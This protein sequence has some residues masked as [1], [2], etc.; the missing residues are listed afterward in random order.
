MYTGKYPRWFTDNA[1]G[2]RPRALSETTSRIFPV[3]TGYLGYNLYIY[4]YIHA[5]YTHIHNTYCRKFVLFYIPS[6]SMECVLLPI[7]WCSVLLQTLTWTNCSRN[8]GRRKVERTGTD[9][10][11]RP[12]SHRSLRTRAR[13]ERRRRSTL[14]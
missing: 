4:M 14:W 6:V 2:L 3:Y 7:D 11:G 8:C 9:C 1:L 12:S 10:Y 5:T 13:E